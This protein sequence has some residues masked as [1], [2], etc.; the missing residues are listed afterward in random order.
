MKRREYACSEERFLHD[1]RDHKMIV[2][3][4]DGVDR[5]LR[6]RREG[7]S[8]Y[9]FD[10]IT[11]NGTLCIDG[12]CGTYVLARLQDMFEFFRSGG[13]RIN[14]A[15]WQEKVRGSS[16][17]EGIEKWS[18]ELFRYAVVSDFRDYWRESND[19]EKRRECWAELREQV[20]GDTSDEHTAMRAAYDFN[21]E[22]FRLDDFF[23]HHLTEYTFH[24]IWCMRAIVWGIQQFDAAQS[25]E[26][27]A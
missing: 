2:V 27:A 22:G 10:L 21:C 1:I 5:H 14:P 18:E 16:R 11:W 13:G 26:A 24:F 19:W 17:H 12:D 25:M 7:T 15:Y 9:W 8:T 3:R 20:L 23:D 4:N 6:F